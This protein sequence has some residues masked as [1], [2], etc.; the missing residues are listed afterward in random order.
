MTPKAAD[1]MRVRSSF[2]RNLASSF[3]TS[4]PAGKLATALER[5]ST[6]WT[7]HTTSTSL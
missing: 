2:V 4:R 3:E 7:T 6:H 5:D 1:E